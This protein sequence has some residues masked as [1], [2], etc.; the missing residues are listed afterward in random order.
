MTTEELDAIEAREKAATPGPWETR[1]FYASAG[2]NDGSRTGWNPTNIANGQCCF[3]ANPS[4]TLV[5][6]YRDEHGTMH[7]HRFSGSDE[8]DR[9]HYVYAMPDGTS[10]AGNYD[11]EDGGIA[12]KPEDADFIA[13][14]RTDIPALVAEVRKLQGELR[15]RDLVEG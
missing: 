7:T 4:G 5:R 12:S 14:A 9:W 6:E 15:R 11:Y 10:I 2:V 3:C 13:H 8:Q 1:V